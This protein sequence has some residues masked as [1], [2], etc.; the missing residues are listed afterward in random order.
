MHTIVDTTGRTPKAWLRLTPSCTILGPKVALGM[1]VPTTLY[2]TGY[3]QAYCSIERL[4]ATELPPPRR[5]LQPPGSPPP[6]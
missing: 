5:A 3:S 6:A 1:L 4:T 2:C